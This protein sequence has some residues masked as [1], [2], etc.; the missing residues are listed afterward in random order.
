MI[1]RWDNSPHWKDLKTFPYHVHQGNNL[2][3]KE[4]S[5]VFMEDVLREVEKLLS[6]G[7]RSN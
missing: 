2:E 5:E 7:M 1:K 4:S 3:P 6:P